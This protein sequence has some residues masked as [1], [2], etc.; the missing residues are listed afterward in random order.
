M[1]IFHTLTL[2]CF[3]LIGFGVSMAHA[4]IGTIIK[5]N[6]GDIVK[7]PTSVLDKDKI[8][9]KIKDAAQ[10]EI[11]NRIETARHDYDTT[12]FSFVVA[13]SD[14]AGV[15]EEKEKFSKLK[16]LTLM[17]S[18]RASNLE[19]NLVASNDPQRDGQ[20]F[21]EL[22]QMSLS[23]SRF[24]MAE[25][26][27][28]KA[29]NVF[30]KNNLTQTANYMQ[31]IAN[32]AL[33][34]HSTGRY[35]E[36]ETFTQT[37]LEQRKQVLGVNSTAYASSLN[38]KAMLYKDLGR[39][40]EAESLINEAIGIVTQTEGKSSSQYAITINNKAVLLQVMGRFTESE[41]LFKEAIQIANSSLKEGSNNYQRLLVNLALLYQ[42]M[43]KYTEAEAIY[44]DAIK[45]KEAQWKK[46][47]PDYAHM[48]NNLA[49]LYVLMGKNSEVEAKLKEAQSI[50]E[51]KFGK[52]HP[53]YASTISNLGNFYR[54]QNRE[55]E[56]EPLLKEAMEISRTVLGESHPKYAQAQEDM[57]LLYW[58]TNRPKEA[59]ALYLQVLEKEDNFVKSYFPAM[60]EAEKEK[61]WNK[62]RPTFMRF[63][64][65]VS[66]YPDEALLKEMYNNH[67]ATKAILLSASNKIK[68]QI[69]SSNDPQL[70]KDYNTWVD[71]KELLAKL[72]EFSKEELT[73]QQINRDSLEQVAN[74]LEKSLSQRSAS[75]SKEFEEE[76]I[77]YEMVKNALVE[78]EAIVDIIQFNW[79]N[80][81]LVP[82][83][84]QYAAVVITKN[85]TA[86]Q[87]VV[88]KNGNEL[89][90][91]YYK[92]YRNLIKNQAADK[93]SYGQYWQ[94]IEPLVGDKTKIYLTLD[95]IY[96][97]VNMATLQK[98]D[99]KFLGE[100]KTFVTLTNAKDILS[101]KSQ[102][103]NTAQ[104]QMALVGFPSYGSAGKITPL[105]G[106]KLEIETIQKI[107]NTAGYKTQLFSGE[108]ATEN[109]VKSFAG[110]SILHIATHGYFQN[111]VKENEDKKI[112]GIEPSK[113]KENPLLRSGLMLAD[114]EQVLEEN[115]K[116]VG[117]DDKDNG[118]LT[119]FEVTTLDLSNVA[120][121][122]LSACETGLGDVKSGEGVYGLQRA[123]K[124]AGANAMIMSL[125]K[126][127]DEATQKL[128]TLFYTEYAKTGDKVLAFKN[129]QLQ[130]K[131]Q[132]KTPY[133][134][135]AFI[136][137]GG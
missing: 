48:L 72:Y 53:S 32:V 127:S 103:S 77:T 41:M 136:L 120:L 1:K 19:N 123:F 58:Q 40:S 28:G 137:I 38:N 64:A 35:A 128:M 102:K 84:V 26:A 65:F 34:Y 111:D 71:T 25:W 70:I 109:K 22:G 79:F 11:E 90:G 68:K 45:R 87:L 24:K 76:N 125:W 37:A 27:F 117:I 135:G 93:I 57:A 95:G 29:M 43:G 106:T 69:L 5:K 49:A 82:D 18:D 88:L 78:D 91:K 99:G 112:F 54:M 98:P 132:F 74:Q 66:Q 96:N 85:Q 16:D 108:Q 113:A 36:A 33:L 42:E 86:P 121:V 10:Q 56:A 110:L 97:Q 52:Q 30:Q 12:T 129:A 83:S 119:A 39:Y 80:K 7:D 124:V 21:N 55:A 59:E 133:Y 114:A 73:E 62:L 122:V 115:E 60:S 3:I 101:F 118:I 14:N 61:Y 46:N 13:F 116:S 20:D 130:L 104:K 8:K 47:H 134:W 131:E 92:V 89:D 9:D 6:A 15:F 50:Y 75:F 4:Q 2:T 51:K 81:K 105:P 100:E 44:L 94:K 67:L 23:G 126:V 17:A 107:M 31:T 63:Y